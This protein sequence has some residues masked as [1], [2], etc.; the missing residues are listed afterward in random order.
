MSENFIKFKHRSIQI[1]ALKIAL[2]GLSFGL[3]TGGTSLLLSKYEAIAMK[4]LFALLIGGA[5]AIAAGA[6]TWLILR[7]SNHALAMQLDKE[8][9]LHEKVQTMIEYEKEDGAIYALQREDA[10]AALNAIPK[11]SLRFRYWWIYLLCFVISVGFF[12]TAFLIKPDTT[13]E[14]PPPQ[15]DPAFA[16]TEI[17]RLALSN[18]ITE[19]NASKMD[20]PYKE[21]VAMALTELLDDLIDATKQSEKAAALDT[22]MEEILDETDDSSPAIELIEALW[23]RGNE[24]VRALVE[25]INHY[26]WAA[27]QEW[28]S[29]YKEMTNFR[30]SF[31][32]AA[33]DEET[34]EEE[35]MTADTAALLT[36]ASSDVSMAL[37]AS[38][39]NASDPIYAVLVKLNTVNETADGANLYGLS[40]L[41]TMAETLGYTETQLALETTVNA[42]NVEIFNALEQSYV[43]VTTGEHTVTRLSEIFG[44]KA[45]KFKRPNLSDGSNEGNAGNEGDHSS[46]NPPSTDSEN[47][48]GSTE[49]VLNPVS[50]EHV[51]Y[52]DIFNGY[53][54]DQLE[55][56]KQERSEEEYEAIKKYF[57]ILAGVD[58][59]DQE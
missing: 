35:Q 37:V 5:A 43:N 30:M 20:S 9:D 6:L 52:G 31:I 23:G 22:A 1:C 36:A 25:A 34:P 33:T 49:K 18:L 56:A 45:P 58:E 57:D 19:V 15:E 48:Y 2:I 32:Y 44:Y 54:A 40:T 11:H 26:G 8:F 27:N 13:E 3:V 39:V 51:E 28:D 14:P 10:E 16:I 42:L 41:A 7:R 47:V 50:G 55:K 24:N 12:L 59:E 53:Q 17:Q 21:N 4:T 29:Y 38:G 46:G